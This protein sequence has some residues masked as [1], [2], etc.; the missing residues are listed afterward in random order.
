MGLFGTGRWLRSSLQLAVGVHTCAGPRRVRP[1][2][3][4][5]A[6]LPRTALARPL[7]TTAPSTRAHK[8]RDFQAGLARVGRAS[9]S[10]SVTVASASSPAGSTS[11]HIDFGLGGESGPAA[12]SCSSVTKRSCTRQCRRTGTRAG[13]RAAVMVRAPRPEPWRR[14]LRALDAWRNRR[15]KGRNLAALATFLTSAASSVFALSETPAAFSDTCP[16]L[17]TPARS[18][19][20]TGTRNPRL[21]RPRSGRASGRSC[22]AGAAAENTQVWRTRD[23][24][25][26][27]WG[28]EAEG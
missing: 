6:P 5:R 1:A 8:G 10:P 20:R 26:S 25:G 3:L 18:P 24:P 7:H 28:L 19:G 21:T 23:A 11:S 14:L 9:T 13:T 12:K 15:G 2:P 17:R 4:V 16:P 27:G 22:L